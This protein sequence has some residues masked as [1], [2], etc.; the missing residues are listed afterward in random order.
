MRLPDSTSLT[1]AVWSSYSEWAIWQSPWYEMRLSA[2]A[3]LL[4]EDS[5]DGLW[6]LFAHSWMGIEHYSSPSGFDWSKVSLVALRGHYPSLYRERNTWH[7]VYESH[8]RDYS[9]SIRLDRKRTISRIW[10]MSSSDL[11]NWSSPQ[12]ILSAADVPYASDFSVPRLAHPQ[13]VPWEG[14]YRLYF[15]ASELKMYDSGQKA[16]ACLSYACSGFINADY[17]VRQKPVLRLDPDDRHADLAPGAFSFVACPDALMAFQSAYSFDEEAGR[18]RS[19]L[20][21]VKRES[22]DFYILRSDDLPTQRDTR[23]VI[24]IISPVLTDARYRWK[25]IYNKGGATIDFYMQDEEFKRQMV[26]DKIAFASGMCIECVLEITRRLSELG[27]VINVSY[28]VTTV[29]RTRFGGMEIITP[30][31]KR[32]LKKMEAEKMQL[33]LFD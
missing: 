24:E 18:S 29:I 3:V 22:F 27:E 6:H 2:P 9:G 33:S 17:E 16:S 26:E 12:M 14:G 20:L 19:G 7:L 5:P 4:P 1:N 13:I 32:H 28:T 21:E 25:G 10:M 11:R 31:G 15:T 23:A 30:Q 8:D